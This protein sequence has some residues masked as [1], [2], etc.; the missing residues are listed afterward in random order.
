[1]KIVIAGLVV[2]SMAVTAFAVFDDCSPIPGE[3]DYEQGCEQPLAPLEGD[4]PTEPVCDRIIE[5]CTC[6]FGFPM[7]CW[8]LCSTSCCLGYSPTS[9][10]EILT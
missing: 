10:E 2:L 9:C 4:G 5:D 7:R 1:M 3:T 6:V 8:G